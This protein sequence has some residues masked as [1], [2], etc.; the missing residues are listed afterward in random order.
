M[1]DAIIEAKDLNKEFKSLK[2]ES[3]IKD[4]FSRN[5]KTV[6]ALQNINLE[7]KKGEFIGIIGPNGAGKSTLIKIL[8]GILTPTSGYAKVMGIIPYK[9]RQENAKNIGVVFGW[10]TQ[11]WWDLLVKDSYELIRCLYKIPRSKFD[12]NLR[13]FS[14]ILNIDDY[15]KKPVR[16]LSLGERVRCDLAASLLYEPPILFLDEPTIGLDVVAKQ[17]IRDFLTKINKEK[18]VTIIITTHD[19]RD[20]EELCERIVIIDKGKKIYDG[21]IRDIKKKFGAERVLVIDF[22]KPIK[23]NE[24]KLKGVKISEIDGNKVF[25]KVNIR[26]VSLSETVRKILS[27]WPIHDMT[28]EEPDIEGIIRRIYRDGI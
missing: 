25:L 23:K 20:I 11:L 24:L 26:K 9:K 21:S 18:N 27:K 16:K 13:T 1:S 28:I 5:Y 17:Q 2:R 6:K 14:S 22:E 3:A 8:T 19:M 7:I 15:L 12:K 4:L 10:R